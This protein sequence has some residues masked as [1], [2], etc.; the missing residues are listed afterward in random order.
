MTAALPAEHRHR[1]TT[2]L[3]AHDIHPDQITAITNTHAANS[4]G[5]GSPARHAQ[6]TPMTDT[7]AADQAGRWARRE[8]LLALLTRGTLTD[9]E[10]PLL[11]AHVEAELAD[12]EK[13]YAE[14]ER[15]LQVVSETVTAANDVGGVDLNDLVDRLAAAGFALPDTE[16]DG[17]S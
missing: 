12:A 13:A 11:R 3:E 10:R 2:H 16:T 9:A 1:I 7:P 14:L 6:E 8:P 4:T 5:T 17:A 15:V